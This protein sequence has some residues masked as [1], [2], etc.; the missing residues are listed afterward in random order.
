MTQPTFFISGAPRCG[1]TALYQYL[2]HHPQIFMSE[3]KELNYFA[4]DFPNV[5]KITFK[6]RQDYLKVFSKAN[7]THLAIG[8][9]SPFYLYSKVAFT[10]LFSFDPKAKIILSLR[11]PIDFVQSFHQLNLS[12]LREDQK[13]LETAWDLQS[14]RLIGNKIPK[15]CRQPELIMYGEL[16]LFGKYVEKLLEIFPRDQV[17]IIIFE[18]FIKQPKRTYEEILAFIGVPSDGRKDFPHVNASFENRSKLM[19]KIFH[20]PQFVYKPFMKFISLFGVNF[21]KSV[22]V[23]YNRIENLN[24]TKAKKT[25]LDPIFHQKLQDYFRDDIKKLSDILDRDLPEWT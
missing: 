18:D 16:G 22:S 9:A 15:S 25:P 2:N 12:L 10:N 7:S 3:V 19:A 6:S 8:E 24:V 1:T 14:Q 23:I 4:Y 13:D 11:N 5:Q 20:P 21:M 17:L